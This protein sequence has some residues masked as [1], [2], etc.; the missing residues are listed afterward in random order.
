MQQQYPSG[1]IS[2]KSLRFVHSI[3]NAGDRDL[4]AGLESFGTMN[5][6]RLLVVMYDIVIGRKSSC[7]DEIETGIHTKALAFI[8]KMYLSIAEDSQIAVATHD[9]SL[10]EHPVLRRDAVRMFEK[11]DNG[12][13]YIKK[14]VYVHNSINLLNVYKKDLDPKLDELIDNVQLFMEYRDLIRDMIDEIQKRK[15]VKK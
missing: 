2:H 7:I 15:P 8:L 1:V 9:L 13:T 10:L 4:D 12:H 3:A 14:R 5:I 6:V 11:D